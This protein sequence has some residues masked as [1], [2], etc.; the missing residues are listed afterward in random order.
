MRTQMSSSPGFGILF[1]AAVLLAVIGIPAER[2]SAQGEDP[3]GDDAL[4]LAQTG[5]SDRTVKAVLASAGRAVPVDLVEAIRGAATGVVAH[6]HGLSSPTITLASNEPRDRSGAPGFSAAERALTALAPMLVTS[7]DAETLAF[8]L[9]A[10]FD[11][12]PS[13]DGSLGDIYFT[14]DTPLNSFSSPSVLGGVIGF[15]VEHPAAAGPD[16]RNPESATPR[17]VARG[18]AFRGAVEAALASFNLPDVTAPATDSGPFTQ[19]QMQEA[20]EAVLAS[21]RDRISEA[22]ASFE[23]MARSIAEGAG[24]AAI[25]GFAAVHRAAT[26]PATVGNPIPRST[27]HRGALAVDMLDVVIRLRHEQTFRPITRRLALWGA[28]GVAKSAIYGQGIIE[29]CNDP[30]ELF[31]AEMEERLSRPILADFG[32]MDAPGSTFAV[33]QARPAGDRKNERRLAQH[34]IPLSSPRR[35]SDPIPREL[36][37][38][39]EALLPLHTD[40]VD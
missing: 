2:I 1:F 13:T 19:E 8:A 7:D 4:G 31:Y 38:D 3:D 21:K 22:M 16:A 26:A 35:H 6:A 28:A 15:P 17:A 32:P 24:D 23:R 37:R 10:P 27:L 9:P 14:L 25:E 39:T 20:L 34:S 5:G 36:E 29:T 18:S 11:D 40:L 12:Y 30:L 33:E